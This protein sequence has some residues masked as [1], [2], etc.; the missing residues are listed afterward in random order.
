MA[1]SAHEMHT[2]KT[3]ILAL[4]LAALLRVAEA[5]A[6]IINKILYLES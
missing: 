4:V 1:V 3:I 5:I 6:H 2:G